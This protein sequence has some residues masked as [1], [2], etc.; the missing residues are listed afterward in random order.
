MDDPYAPRTEPFVHWVLYNIPEAVT[1]I[2]EG[3]SAGS[4]GKNDRDLTSYFGPRPPSGNHH[5]HFKVYALDTELH[6]LAPPTKKDLLQAMEGHVLAK[7]EL[8]GTFAFEDRE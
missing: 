8:I 2:E 1:S 5:Y 6:F 7:G 4:E 3:K